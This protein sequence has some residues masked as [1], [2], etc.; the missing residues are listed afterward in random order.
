MAT[1]E[2]YSWQLLPRAI[3]KNHILVGQ[4]RLRLTIENSAASAAEELLG[5]VRRRL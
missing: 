1:V 3:T 5:E 2:I 4:W